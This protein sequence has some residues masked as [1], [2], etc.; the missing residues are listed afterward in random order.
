MGTQK[1]RTRIGTA[2]TAQPPPRPPEDQ[3]T[4]SEIDLGIPENI[5]V[6]QDPNESVSSEEPRLVMGRPM[7]PVS[8][9]DLERAHRAYAGANVD[10]VGN[11]IGS[12]TNNQTTEP[13]IVEQQPTKNTVDNTTREAAKKLM[14]EAFQ[15]QVNQAR[16]AQQVTQP[17]APAQP[18]MGNAE[19]AEAAN[20]FEYLS[21]AEDQ[22]IEAGNYEAAAQAHALTNTL[23]SRFNVKQV[24]A[25]QDRHP[26][27][28]KLLQ[29]LGL[30]RIKNQEIDWGGSR[31]MFAPTNP[32]L[33]KW[34]QVNTSPDGLN[35]GAL[36]IAASTVA[37]DG[38]AIYRVLGIPAERAYEISPHDNPLI[39]KT[40][41]VRQFKRQCSCGA[42]VLVNTDTCE[43]CG[44][45][46]DPFDI[47]TELRLE[48]C[49]LFYNILE[50]K[51]GAYE[52]LI[53]LVELRDKVMKDR[54][55]NRDELYPLLTP[56]PK[57]EKTQE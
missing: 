21:N 32:R 25:R 24:S 49:K 22:A 56:S 54:I 46:L 55:I 53:N 37:L 45:S 12:R 11:V 3:P 1:T 57:P 18:I 40:V 26:A 38:V 39:T 7:R 2:A 30:E 48:C 51:F 20:A 47:P 33:D 35:I 36:L 28:Q 27:L 14:P 42:V 44:T 23:R 16:P 15:T 19:A 6:A 52:E 29:N 9:E 5:K 34:V 4:E 13:D 43:L 10:M 8:P 41:L 50:E 17:T 31:W